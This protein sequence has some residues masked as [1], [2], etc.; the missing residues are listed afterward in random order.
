MVNFV[1]G[2][3]FKVVVSSNSYDG[4]FETFKYVTQKIAQ[5]IGATV[6]V[7]QL[8]ASAVRET[9]PIKVSNTTSRRFKNAIACHLSET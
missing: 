3:D 1:F 7:F 4:L 5:R 8:F 9:D 6:A 2:S